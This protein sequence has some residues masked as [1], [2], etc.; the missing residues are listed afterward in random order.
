MASLI[1]TRDLQWIFREQP[2]S[3][4]GIDAIV[5]IVSA[6]SATGNLLALQ[7]K[8]G[9]SFF[10]QPT[11]DGFL[12]RGDA[13][14]LGYWLRYP[15]PVLLILC[16]PSQSR[17]WWQL[18]DSERVTLTGKGWKTV[19]PLSNELGQTS[20]DSIRALL[21]AWQTDRRE[22]ALPAEDELSVIL[23]WLGQCKLVHKLHR[24]AYPPGASQQFS[25][26]DL[27]AAFEVNDTAIPVLI[28][29][30]D[31]SS[32]GLPSWEPGHVDLLQR[33][34]DLLKM[35]L[36]IAL[37]YLDF[38]ALFEARHLQTMG[39]K[40]TISFPEAMKETLLGILAGDFS[41]SFRPGVGMH[42]KILKGE[43]TT[44]EALD[45]LIEEAYLLNDK[46]E[47]HTGA[48]GL[49]QLLRA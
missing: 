9:D 33:Y 19:V 22:R 2:V 30:A 1:F 5:E 31:W 28:D 20:A 45:G 12:F 25:I 34:A 11:E 15:I 43:R 48:G 14:H 21:A 27:V 41:F 16:S 44:D 26:P 23:H 10:D 13:Q 7:I 47:R 38:W 36:L 39:D 3:D 46:G 42:L 37:K 32:G 8:S 24:F 17:C 6:G 18:I 4:V 40:L 35:P 49:F 29:V